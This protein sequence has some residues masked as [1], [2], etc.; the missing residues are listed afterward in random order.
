MSVTIEITSAQI[1]QIDISQA[2]SV[3]ATLSQDVKAHEQ[4]VRCQINWEREAG[5]PRELSEIAEVRLWFI[6]LDARHPYLPLF[7]DWKAGE[8]ARYVAMLVPH[9]FHAKDG[10]LFNP[11]ALEIFV[12]QR[13]FVLL[14]WLNSQGI[15]GRS[16]LQAMTKMLGYELDNGFFDLLGL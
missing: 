13:T 4:S 11:E 10:I 14:D 5:D 16:R 15:D 2:A 12:M 3:L 1:Q 9:Q 6:R 8:L 7:L